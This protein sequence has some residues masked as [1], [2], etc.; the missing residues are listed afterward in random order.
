[1]QF[2]GSSIIIDRGL[3]GVVGISPGVGEP[4]SSSGGRGDA[5]A[6]DVGVIE[7]P[8]S[9]SPSNFSPSS[10]DP[11]SPPSPEI[12]E[13]SL[14]LKL[15]RIFYENSFG[16]TNAMIYISFAVIRYTRTRISLKIFNYE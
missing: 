11:S 8:V 15:F 13:L 3:V 14:L 12:N 16:R 1:M 7:P 5:A 2:I 10:G 4:T 9:S 6:V